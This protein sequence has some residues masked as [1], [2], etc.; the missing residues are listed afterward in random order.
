MWAMVR[1]A[2]NSGRIGGSVMTMAILTWLVAIPMLGMVTG[3]RTMM[4]MA[5]LCWFAYLGHLPVE[6]TWAFWAGKLV[7]AIVFTVLAAGE[8]VGDKLPKTPNRTDP[9]PLG[10]RVVFAGLIGAIV[11]TALGG[12]T[13]EGVILC[14]G[15][16]LI[17]AFGGFLIRREL[18]LQLGGKDWPVAV[19]EDVIAVG[20]AVLAMGVVTG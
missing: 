3:M 16:A 4:G 13:I 8:L 2:G 7:T 20:C 9:G 11:A 19:L 1:G 14:V 18:V 15:G 5:V 17:G 6:D 10:A 12:S